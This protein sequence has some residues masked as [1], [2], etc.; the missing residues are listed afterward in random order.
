MRWITD[1]T[2]N[3]YRAFPKSET[4]SIPQGQHL[5]IYGENGSGKSSIYNAIKDF[6]RSS[7]PAPTIAFNLN[8]FEKASHNTIGEVTLKIAEKDANGN[9][10]ENA[11]TFSEPPSNSTHQQ[12]QIQLA[13]KMK[14]FLDYKKLLRVHALNIPTNTQPNVFDLIV[15][16]LLGEHRVANP[17][18]GATTVEFLEEYGRL[19]NILRINPR[20]TGKYKTAEAELS[21]LN[22]SL[23]ALLK[24][25]ITEANK[26]LGQYFKNKITLDIYYNNLKIHK[27]AKAQSRQM[28]EE[29]FLRVFYAGNEIE[30]YHTFLNEA[31]LSAVAICL[32]LASIRTNSLL[33]SDLRVLFLDDVFI[34]LDT[35]NRI[36][37]LAILRDEFAKQDFQIFISTYDRQWFELAHQWFANNNCVFK[38]LEMYTNDDG[39]PTTPEQPV[40]IDKSSDQFE[41][42]KRHFDSKDYPAA[43]NYLRKACEKELRRILP[44][45]K[46]L[47]ANRNTGEVKKIDKLETLID[48]FFEYAAKNGLDCGPFSNFKTYKKIILNPLSHDDLEAPHYRREIQAGIDLVQDL[49]QIKVR[50]IIKA[51]DSANKPMKLGVKDTV[52]GAMHKYEITVSENLKILQQNNDPVKLS[53]VACQIVE[54]ATTKQFSSLHEAFNQIRVERSSPAKP[55]YSDFY[56]DIKITDSKRLI[57]CIVF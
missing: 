56:S 36:P 17:T 43:A 26:F 25:V 48:N 10:I 41:R 30:G 33:V 45:N 39:N 51:E 28:F 50:D 2:I 29:L 18:G 27:P 8:E 21:N 1:I 34:G 49:Q 54:G 23:L 5:L 20:H 35:S 38:T 7:F 47:M 19:V 24:Q 13:N 31:R 15:K 40:I 42:A 9:P 55:D 52:S 6:F 4:I 14:G 16:D 37:L 44:G 53:S 3:N 11:Y 46:T 57:D 12:P 32:Y 22:V